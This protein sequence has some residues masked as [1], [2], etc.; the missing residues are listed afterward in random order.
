MSFCALISFSVI[1]CIGKDEEFPTKPLGQLPAEPEGLAP[2]KANHI[3]NGRM[4]ALPSP[5]TATET[6]VSANGEKKDLVGKTPQKAGKKEGTKEATPSEGGK[7]HVLSSQNLNAGPSG[8]KDMGPRWVKPSGDRLAAMMEG[9]MILGSTVPSSPVMSVASEQP[10]R[11]RPRSRGFVPGSNRGSNAS[12]YDNVPVSDGDVA[13][14]PDFTQVSEPSRQYMAPSVRHGSPTRPP[15]GGIT[16]PTFRIPKNPPVH[17]MP[18][19]RQPFHHAPGMMPVY[20]PYPPKM[21]P[22]NRAYGMAY[23]ER[24]Y[25]TTARSTPP[26]RSPEKVLIDNS[27]ATY[28]RQPINVDFIGQMDGLVERGHFPRQPVRHVDQRYERQWQGQG[29]YG[30]TDVDVT[31]LHTPAGLARSKSF[32]KA[33]LSPVHPG[34][35]FSFPS[36]PVSDSAMHYRAVPGK[37]QMP[38]VFG[39]VHYRQEAFAMQESMLL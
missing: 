29:W 12:Q 6:T 23:N 21:Q 11:H 20:S 27:Y 10:R 8:R 4:E 26:N 37:K 25:G 32:Q 31:F 33:Q 34:Q 30:E 36:V 9:H 3:A 7:P 5:S 19:P 35:E 39:G 2:E 14:I 1:S 38:T 16:A 28:Q 24:A 13:D 22:E 17:L 15:S 18:D